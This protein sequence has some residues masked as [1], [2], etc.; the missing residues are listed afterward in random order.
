MASDVS[1]FQTTY[2]A[3]IMMLT[4]PSS[5]AF[6]CTFPGCEKTFGVRSNMKRHL[7]THRPRLPDYWQSELEYPDSPASTPHDV[8][9]PDS[10]IRTTQSWSPSQ[11]SAGYYSCS[12][13]DEV[14]IASNGSY[15]GKLDNAQLPRRNA[16]VPPSDAQLEL[17]N[18]KTATK[19]SFPFSRVSRALQ[20]DAAILMTIR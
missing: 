4:A 1:S 8:Q 14:D 3:P 6:P 20:S 17:Y 2:V 19:S 13:Y 10:A 9:R 18:Q 15:S 11:A 12:D 16:M 7:R 5:T